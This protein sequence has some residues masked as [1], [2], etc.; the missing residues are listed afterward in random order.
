MKLQDEIEF[1]TGFIQLTDSQAI[2]RDSLERFLE[3]RSKVL[4]VDADSMLYN[5]VYSNKDIDKP[6]NEQLTDFEAQINGVKNAV[7]SDGFEVEDIIYFFTTC[8][9]NFRKDILPSYKANRKPNEITKQVGI[10][11]KYVIQELEY[12]LQDVRYSDTL[13]ADDLVGTASRDYGDSC[14]IVAI[15]KDLKQLEGAH[16]NYYKDK[17]K[18]PEGNEITEWFETPTGFNIK[19]VKKEYRGWQFTTK[20]EGF[21]LLLCQLLIGDNSDNIKGVDKIGAKKAP[22]LIEGKTNF[23]MLRAVYEAYNDKDRLKMNISLM[24]M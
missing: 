18:D 6:L 12:D 9:N 3:E 24:K 11:K 14:I 2:K 21:E 1:L 7:E 4:L 5:V 22:K 23:G 17:M 20:Q 8:R 15:D 13:E 10:L 16:F 19:R